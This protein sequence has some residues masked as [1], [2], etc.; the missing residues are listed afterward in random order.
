MQRRYQKVIEEAPSSV[1]TP[2][3]RAG[4]SE[5]AR[6]AAAAVGYVGAG[7]VEFIADPE[8]NFYFL[9]MNT[10]LQVEHPV[11]EEVYGVDL[12]KQQLRI[13]SGQKLDIDQS[14]IEPQGHAIEMRIYAEDPSNNFMPSIGRIKNLNLPEGPGV[15]NE[16]S[17]YPGYDIPVFYDPLIGKLVVWAQTRDECIRRARRA[18]R[19]YRADGIRTNVDFLLWALHEPGFVDGS[20]D[21]HYIENH[22]DASALTRHDEEIDLAAIAAAIAAFDH[23]SNV[24]YRFDSASNERWRRVARTEGMRRPMDP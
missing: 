3:M 4:L 11:T 1:V 12:V 7:T 6:K 21:T 22:F 2:E 9:E 20:Y 15:R 23:A 24:Q 14:T 19:E 8:G 13:A 10:R 5:A 18:L 16:N 17:V